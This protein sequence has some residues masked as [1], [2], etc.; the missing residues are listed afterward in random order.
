MTVWE[1]K[2]MKL[3]RLNN[4]TETALKNSYKHTHAL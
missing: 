1:N 4:Y 3:Q 2:F